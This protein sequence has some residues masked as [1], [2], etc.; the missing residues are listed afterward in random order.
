METSLPTAAR[1]CEF[2]G[3]PLK[4]KRVTLFGKEKDVA[5]FGSCDCDRAAEKLE[6]FGPVWHETT[7]SD[8]RC[9]MCGCTMGLDG[10]TGYVSTCPQC[11]Y[12][13]V[14]G[15][16]RE[17]VE[18]DRAA[19]RAM[20][21]GSILADT[22]VPRLY[23]TVEPDYELAGRVMRGKGLYITGGNGTYKTLKAASVAMAFAELG[24]SV[25]F[26]SSIRLLS[27]FKDTYGTSRSED[28]VFE[29]LNRC[30]LLVVDDLG[31]ENQTSWASS[32]LYAV[33]DGRYGSA[34]PIVVTTNYSEDEL[35]ARLSG[36]FDESTA[37][38][39][40][41]RLCEMTEKMVLD[42]PDRRLQ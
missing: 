34:K 3:R 5:C 39:I 41:S 20:M 36:T 16:D 4:R 29:E 18:A 11:G 13:C 26:A 14:F 27:D 30:D 33:I 6:S 17:R 19:E 23:W 12:E 40:V 25:R 2:C 31:K 22:G 37:K 42:G 15:S 9:P 38:A 1:A 24:K 7:K 8:H 10:F 28:D 21:R 32:M 35:A